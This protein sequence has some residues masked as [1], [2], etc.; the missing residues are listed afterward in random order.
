MPLGQLV[1]EARV[2]V[3]KCECDFGAMHSL[4]SK[5]PQAMDVER[6]VA[7]AALLI[8]T[9]PPSQLLRLSDF[10]TATI[11]CVSRVG[12]CETLAIAAVD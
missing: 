9:T 12:R 6:V 2:R 4:L 5:L 11:A 3:L 7:R 1:L 8:H 10:D